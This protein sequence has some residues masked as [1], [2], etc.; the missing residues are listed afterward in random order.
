MWPS[1]VTNLC[2]LQKEDVSGNKLLDKHAVDIAKKYQ[3]LRPDDD[4]ENDSGAGPDRIDRRKTI[5]HLVEHAAKKIQIG[6]L[7]DAFEKRFFEP[8]NSGPGI[9]N[10]ESSA[11]QKE[12]EGRR[13][14]ILAERRIS[15]MKTTGE[16]KNFAQ[17]NGLQL[18]NR[19]NFPP[20]PVS[21]DAGH[22]NNAY[23]ADELAERNP[24]QM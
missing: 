2:F 5:H 8:E 9:R 22:V 13:K 19:R 17:I 21:D 15:K 16:T 20:A 4:Y 12:L 3:R 7:E 18:R 10:Q 14:T 11:L 23:V 6:T 24:L 1:I